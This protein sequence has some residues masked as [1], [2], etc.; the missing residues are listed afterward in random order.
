MIPLF[1]RSR[2]GSPGI[3]ARVSEKS[4]VPG[5]SHAWK[6]HPHRRDWLFQYNSVVSIMKMRVSNDK[7]E[8]SYYYDQRPVSP[9]QKFVDVLDQMKI[10]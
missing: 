8:F 9:D 7:H 2:E 4:G 6:K 10:L 1:L 3:F 5:E